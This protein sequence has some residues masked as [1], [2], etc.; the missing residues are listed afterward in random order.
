MTAP[1]L[2]SD[3]RAAADAARRRL[4]MI[5]LHYPPANTPG[6]LRAS[7]LAKHLAPHGWDTTVLTA[8]PRLPASADPA[9]PGELPVAQRVHT[10]AAWDVKELFAWLGRYPG[11]L[12]V[13]DRWLSWLPFA[14]RQARRILRRE[15]VHALFSTSPVPTSHLI[16]L[17]IRAT[18]PLPWIAELR[19]PWVTPQRRGGVEARLERAVMQRADGIVSTTDE[20][21][22]RLA[23]RYGAAVAAKIRVIPN[24]YDED[25]FR[26]LPVAL[27]D[28]RFRLTH[29]GHLYG[30]LRHPGALLHALRRGLDAGVLP[31]DTRLDFLGTEAAQASPDLPREI[32]RLRLADHVGFAARVAHRQALIAMQ[33][34]AVLVVLQS[35]ASATQVPSKCFEYLRSRRPVLAL[36]P[37]ASATARVLRGFAGV[38]VVEPDDVAGIAAAL[39]LLHKQWSDGMVTVE[40]C[41]GDLARYERRR[42]AAD[43]A[44]LL[45]ALIAGPGRR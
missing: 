24:G 3:P 5:S 29:A 32:A 41:P 12:A 34:S 11:F 33:T 36:T 42:A 31:T 17:A 1:A 38:Q 27:P 6:G 18:T 19:D 45:D 28:G 25:D 4:L 8:P 2:A 30:D 44:A 21:A 23:A 22:A 9:P 15:P 14:L 35:G 10:A 43:L 16:A 13:P 7:K 37:A 20:L 26:D 40:R 39:A